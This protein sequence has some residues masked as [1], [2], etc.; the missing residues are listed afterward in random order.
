MVFV[1]S[2]VILALSDRISEGGHKAE[3]AEKGS[4]AGGL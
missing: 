2:G 4:S 1:F 3:H